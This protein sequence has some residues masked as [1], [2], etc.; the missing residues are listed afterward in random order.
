MNNIMNVLNVLQLVGM[1]AG[2]GSAPEVSARVREWCTARA[3]HDHLRRAL[4]A[5][6]D[7]AHRAH[8]K[9]DKVRRGARW[10]L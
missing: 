2:G 3:P 8:R 1:E 4:A 9:Y 7:T 6:A 10:G 5:A